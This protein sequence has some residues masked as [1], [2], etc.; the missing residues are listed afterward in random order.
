MIDLSSNQMGGSIQLP[1][2]WGTKP[3]LLDLSHCT[4]PLSKASSSNGM[5]KLTPKDVRAI[6]F[7]CSQFNYKNADIGSIHVGIVP[8]VESNSVIFDPIL[9]ESSID[10]FSASGTWAQKNGQLMSSF[11]GK[12]IS[13]NMGNSL[14]AWGVPTDVQDAKGDAEFSLT[15]PGSPTDISMKALSGE[16]DVRMQNGRFIGVNPGFGRMLGLLSFQGLQRRLRLDFSDVFKEGFAFDT[17]K[18][19]ISIASGNAYTTNAM[20]KAPAADINFSGRTGLV[21]HDLDFDMLVQAHIDSTIP[22]AAV[23]I[24]NPAAGAAVWIV[25]KVFNPL[26]SVTRYRYHVTGTW[27]TPVFTDLT[28]EYRQELDGPA[29]VEEAK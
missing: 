3:L 26:G 9:L 6:D 17:F 4:W 18:S 20:L 29:K 11:T 19:N 23:A 28:K 10:K 12:A 27:E 22:A 15:W 21:S 14:R 1:H 25:D 7:K 24:A 13:S 8:H 5:S 16:L 2:R